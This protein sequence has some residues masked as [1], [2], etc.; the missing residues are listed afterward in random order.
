[1]EITENY[2]S[3]LDGQIK[4]LRQK[5]QVIVFGLGVVGELVLRT[6]SHLKIDVACMTDNNEKLQGI[7]FHGHAVLPPESAVKKYP[8]AGVAIAVMNN[9]NIC[10]IMAQLKGLKAE[11]IFTYDVFLYLYYT[12]VVAR[13]P[14]GQALKALLG[15]LLR[16]QNRRWII[17]DLAHFITHKCTLRCQDCGVLVP[18][19][20]KPT[21]YTPGALAED[22]T[23]LSLAVDAIYNVNIMGG[24]PMLHPD[25]VQIC[26]AA[27]RLP[28]VLNITLTTNGTFVP[29][30]D[31]E[32]LSQTGVIFY[33]S[34][35]GPLS[36]C[37]K[38]LIEK[39]EQYHIL[40]IIRDDQSV[41]YRIAPPKAQNR[42]DAE[43]MT[44]YQDCIWRRQ[45][46]Q[47]VDGR[48]FSC[49]YSGMAWKLGF[50]KTPET[51]YADIRRPE[52]GMQLREKIGALLNDQK[53][54]KACGYCGFS[55]KNF[56]PRA[57]QMKRA[58]EDE[59]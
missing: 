3:F 12:E 44:V 16:Q 25:L 7:M 43:N 9:E 11:G 33:I 19:T 56:A 57:L 41:W 32:R 47:L 5:R 48:L 21:H 23:Q 40:Y 36:A 58:E 4:A 22:L 20:E 39:L 30:I 10:Q 28:N 49:E 27:A 17:F 51:D 55:D 18:Y 15:R 52:T 53:Q 34:D 42:T 59:A 35:Y 1:M 45:C 2:T 26:E 31:Y 37:K 8:E 6:L 46:I 54:L 14:D 38:K 13:F 29:N 24:E 50:L